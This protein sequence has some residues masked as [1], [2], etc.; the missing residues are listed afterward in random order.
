MES[1]V[2]LAHKRCRSGLG[3]A[4]DSVVN[5][6][7][8]VT[9]ARRAGPPAIPVPRITVRQ[10]RII[11]GPRGVARMLKARGEGIKRMKP[12]DANVMTGTPDKDYNH[13]SYVQACLSYAA[14][15]DTYIH[16]ATQAGG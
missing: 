15:L 12:D 4:L 1:P 7:T 13:I 16:D 5:V 8:L 3:P 11:P 10:A 6:T 14:W 2:D 9:D